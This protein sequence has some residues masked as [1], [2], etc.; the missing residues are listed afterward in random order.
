M[1]Q[2]R[3]PR[4]ISYIVS[5]RTKVI[6]LHDACFYIR[7]VYNLSSNTCMAYHK[8]LSCPDLIAFKTY[9]MLVK[10]NQ[11]NTLLLYPM[12]WDDNP[13]K[14][15]HTTTINNRINGFHSHNWGEVTRRLDECCSQACYLP[16]LVNYVMV[17]LKCRHLTLSTSRVA[18]HAHRTRMD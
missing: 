2:T 11:Y 3:R 10:S 15:L 7:L 9:L 17:I 18:V 13:A 6:W 8:L 4:W 14:T 16:T 5:T 1:W 12:Q